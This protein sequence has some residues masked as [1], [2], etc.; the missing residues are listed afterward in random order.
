MLRTLMQ[1]S[2]VWLATEGATHISCMGEEGRGHVDV[3]G[4]DALPEGDRFEHGFQARARDGVRE[5]LGGDER[6]GVPKGE[7]GVAAHALRRNP[8]VLR[9]ED[10]A[11][12]GVAVVGPAV[13]DGP[14]A[15]A[16]RKLG[17]RREP[18]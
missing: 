18:R 1:G 2:G 4:D 17:R 8:K 13:H 5:V 16:L 7:A 15:R 9:A 12:V 10:E 3:C 6:E 11:E 14:R